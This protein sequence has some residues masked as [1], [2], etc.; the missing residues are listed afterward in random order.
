ML[1]SDRWQVKLELE[2]LYGNARMRLLVESV[3]RTLKSQPVAATNPGVLALRLDV[4]S[5][6]SAVLNLTDSSE[7]VRILAIRTLASIVVAPPEPG[8]RGS[9][10]SPSRRLFDKLQATI[11][12]KGERA[13]LSDSLFDL[14]EVR[15]WIAFEQLVRTAR[16]DVSMLARIVATEA[17]ARM[18]YRSALLDLEPPFLPPVWTLE[19]GIR[20]DP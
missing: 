20:L 2:A 12:K 6:R 3:E 10:S 14:H 13:I 5:I 8:Q 9:T 16:A 17:L 11:I 7:D 15:G 18:D 19:L 4:D 1:Q